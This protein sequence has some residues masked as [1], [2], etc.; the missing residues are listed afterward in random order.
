LI[1]R[2]GLVFSRIN[3]AATVF[4][5]YLSALRSAI[6]PPLPPF[7]RHT[8]PPGILCTTGPADIPEPGFIPCCSADA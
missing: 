4:T 1:T 2:A 7:G 6:T 5:E 3:R 8:P